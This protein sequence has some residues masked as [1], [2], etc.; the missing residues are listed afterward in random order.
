[1][2]NRPPKRDP[3]PKAGKRGKR[4]WQRTATAQLSRNAGTT[5]RRLLKSGQGVTKRRNSDAADA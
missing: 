1:M 4:N 2:P 3:L 5:T